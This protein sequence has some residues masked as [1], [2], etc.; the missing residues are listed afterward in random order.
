[1]SA[2]GEA[3]KGASLLA[4]RK[5]AAS[6]VPAV[7]A[8]LQESPET[9]AW[10]QE[11]LLQLTCADPAAWVVELKGV[12]VGFLIGRV[13][14]DEFEI[15]N[16]AV[17]QAHRR[18]GIGSKVLDTALEFSRTAGSAR[19]YLEVRA[20]NGPALAL[21]KRHGFGE[22]GRRAQ[23]YRDPVEDALLLSLRLGERTWKNL[24]KH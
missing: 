16:M 23:Y 21:Y 8:I 20:S 11:S 10:S 2:G 5:L 14:V 18:S 22:S 13:V 12:L 17:S 7:S 19:A 6:D 9:A 24:V 4:I 1:M 3:S 15:L